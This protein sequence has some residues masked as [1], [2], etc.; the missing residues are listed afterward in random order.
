MYVDGGYAGLVQD[1][2]GTRETLTLAAGRHHIEIDA[3]GY[4]PMTFEVDI[5]PGQIVPYQGS[6]PPS[7]Y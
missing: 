6:L 7:R 5:V 3:S 1:F 2:D 4:E